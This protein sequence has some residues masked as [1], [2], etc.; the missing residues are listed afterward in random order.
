MAKEV[1]RIMSLQLRYVRDADIGALTRIY[2]HYVDQSIMTFDSVHRLVSKEL[3]RYRLFT[4]YGRFRCLVA[5]IDGQIVGSASTNPYREHPAFEKTVEVSIY[6]A[7]EARGQGIGTKLYQKL[8][9]ELRFEDIHTMVSGIALPNDASVKM[10]KRLGFEEVGVFKEYAEKNGQRINSMWLQ[11]MFTPVKPA[12]QTQRA[13]NDDQVKVQHLI[14]SI[15]KEYQLEPD[16]EETDA[17]LTHLE[18]YYFAD[19]GWFEIAF[20][21]SGHL[22]GTWG[23]KKIKKTTCELRKMYL[24]PKMRGMGVGKYLLERA[25]LKAKELGYQTVTLETAEVL[26]EAIGLYKK[27]GFEPYQPQQ[28]SRRCDQSF[29]MT[30]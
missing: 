20:D 16:I 27:Y 8:F 23:I 15:L 7:N 3:E 25:L 21:Q 9:D 14:F 4:P 18:R 11:K 29:I 19:N 5:E 13:T 17:D 30:L 28:I 12:V 26:K 6:L 22:V 2:N 1:G 10:H 24:D